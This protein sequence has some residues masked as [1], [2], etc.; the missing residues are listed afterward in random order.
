MSAGEDERPQSLQTTL[1]SYDVDI[2]PNIQLLLRIACTLPV[3]TWEN[4]RCNN[5][6]KTYKDLS[7]ATMSEE[8][9]SALAMMKNP[10]TE[11]K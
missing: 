6:L 10:S 5:Q 4:E 8:R 11:D 9:L 2:F 7:R 3:T 1:Y